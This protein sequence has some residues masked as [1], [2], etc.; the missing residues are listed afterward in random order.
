ME[1]G[2]QIAAAVMVVAGLIAV[3]VYQRWKRTSKTQIEI[4]ERF[5]DDNEP[6]KE[7]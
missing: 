7:G 5:D 2:L 1:T 4:D 6:V 3:V